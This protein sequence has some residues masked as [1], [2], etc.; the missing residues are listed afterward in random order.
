MMLSLSLDF[1]FNECIH[2]NTPKKFVCSNGI[3]SSGLII[4]N[5]VVFSKS[6]KAWILHEIIYLFIYLFIKN[7]RAEHFLI[8]IYMC[9]KDITIII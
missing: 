5:R 1:I 6:L 7:L 9:R 4:S 8:K 2:L 3:F